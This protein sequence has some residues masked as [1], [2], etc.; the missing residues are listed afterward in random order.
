MLCPCDRFPSLQRLRFWL[1]TILHPSSANKHLH[2]EI[3]FHIEQQTA[4]YIAAGMPPQ[5]ARS[6]AIRAFGNITALKEQATETW[7]WAWL[8]H[9]MQDLRYSV[10][11]LRRS[12]AFALTVVI[13]LALSIGANLAIFELLRGVLFTE[14]PVQQPGQLYSL[15]AVKSPFDEQWFFSY[16]AYQ[17]LKQTTQDVAPVI[18][19]S[20]IS[21]GIV[22]SHTGSS[23]RVRFQ[24][25]SDNFFNVLGLRPVIGRF[26]LPSDDEI[27]QSFW[28]IVLRYGYWKQSL[29]ADRSVLGARFLVNNV[30]V[31]VAGIAPERFS[32]VVAGTAPDFW[33]PLGAQS[34]G[35]F[36]SW[37]DSLGP[38]SG[39]DID[40]PYMNQAGVFWLWLL[41]RIPN[42]AQPSVVNHWTQ[43]LASDLTLLADAAKDPNEREQIFATRVRLISAA[44]GEGNFR[45]DY[46]EPLIVLMAMAA[47]V[48]LVG[49]VNLANL[50]LTRLLSRQRE[51]AVRTALGAARMQILRQLFVEDL[52]LALI[53][54]AVAFVVSSAASFVLLRWASGTGPL[55]PVDLRMTWQL[56]LFGVALLAVSL[57]SFSLFP[58]WKI[59][60]GNLSEDIRAR[61]NSPT[62]QSR[63][64]YKWSGLLLTGQITLSLLLLGMTALFAQ[65]LLNLSHVDAGLDRKHVVSV[66]LD[67][68]NAGYEETELPELYSRLLFRLRELPGI[69]DAALQRCAIPGCVW[70]TS[71]HVFGHPEFPEKQL[72]AEENHVGARYFHTIGIPISQGREFDER[73]LPS[74]QPVAILNRTF[75]HKLFGNENPVGHR[76]GYKS[77][78]YDADY[79]VVGECADALVD[80]LRSP[81]PPVIYFSADQ[82]PSPVGTIVLRTGGDNEAPLDVTIRESLLS[83]DPLLPITSIVPL[84]SDYQEGLS[85]EA[86]LARLTSVFGI[87]ALALAALGFY[88]LLSFNVARRTA[89]IGIRISVGAVPAQIRMMIFKEIAWILLAGIPP[90]ILLTELTARAV[91]SLLYGSASLDFWALGF[92][93]VLLVAT[94]MLAGLVPAQ[95][96][97]TIDP[98][99]ALGTE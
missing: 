42:Q 36:H 74:S 53:G 45:Q 70:N 61:A 35:R 31:V 72:H 24:L 38:G 80:D 5:E 99:K 20:G 71:I 96:A 23:A 13:T 30:P 91:K 56:V 50:Q 46:S 8:D 10:R 73:D 78:P 55:I 40:A 76:I 88:G 41:A 4:E 29:G 15:R 77:P 3:E 85:R 86:L 81:A 18:A 32:G 16:P 27:G 65:T 9:V 34:S 60:R 25:V 62:T 54:G 11:R 66:H 26:F 95:R 7:H 37:F 68:T 2:D 79:V 17:R 98:V 57:I 87:I 49:C 6:A 93:F 58:T 84:D 48:L 83:V 47:L 22:Q 94:G 97:A 67:L 75:S 44:L 90:G 69:R 14:L 21:E 28:P 33:L 39:A 89:E 19:R 82:R 63:S 59:T 92:A 52:L 51:I 1:R 43:A 64:T 12:P